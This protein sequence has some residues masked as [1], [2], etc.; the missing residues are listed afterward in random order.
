LREELSYEFKNAFIEIAP[1]VRG[2]F[3]VYVDDVLV[4]SRLKLGEYKY[5]KYTHI[6]PKEGEVIQLIRELG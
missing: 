5:D 6:F 2:S 3:E 4:Y 1:G